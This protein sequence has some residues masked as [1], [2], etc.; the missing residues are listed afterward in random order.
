VIF[1]DKPWVSTTPVVANRGL[2]AALDCEKSYGPAGSVT[3]IDV[4]QFITNQCGVP[5]LVS[6]EALNP[7]LN[8]GAAGDSQEVQQGPAPAN[9]E[10][11][12][13]LFP[14][15]SIPG[16]SRQG[17]A[18]ARSLGMSGLAIPTTVSGIKFNGRIS[19]LLD[20]VTSRLGLSWHYS[21]VERAVRVNYFETKVFD[22]YAF[23]DKQKIESVVRSGMTTTTGTGSGASGGS[24]S[25]SGSSGES[26]SNQSTK[27]TLDT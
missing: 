10:S 4:A 22:V 6:P 7:G 26:G 17:G 27:V 16:P 2:P 21:P 19:A 14:A 12:A 1:S 25:A 20:L 9:P 11:L 8:V 13:E 3:I 15:G 5:V 23:G 18:S 24:S